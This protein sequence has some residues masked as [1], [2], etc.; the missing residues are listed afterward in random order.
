M[1]FIPY[2]SK[3]LKA[4]SK[5]PGFSSFFYSFFIIPQNSMTFNAKQKCTKINFLSCTSHRRLISDYKRRVNRTF[6]IPEMITAVCIISRTAFSFFYLFHQ[7]FNRLNFFWEK[8]RIKSQLLRYMTITRTNRCQSQHSGVLRSLFIR[9]IE[10]T[11]IQHFYSV[12][13][14]NFRFSS[15]PRLLF[16]NGCAEKHIPPCSFTIVI[17]S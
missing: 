10:R 3:F 16:R 14:M 11:S 5:T 8:C 6:H 7:L 13:T 9:I 17:N 1:L 15:S 12:Q 4:G 2:P